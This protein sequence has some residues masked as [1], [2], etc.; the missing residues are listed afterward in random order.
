MANDASLADILD[1][2]VQLL[3]FRQESEQLELQA[4]VDALRAPTQTDETVQA[5]AKPADSFTVAK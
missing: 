5:D 2:V 1:K 4:K 3:P